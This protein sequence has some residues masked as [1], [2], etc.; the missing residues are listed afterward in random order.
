[1][2]DTRRLEEL[3]GCL[4]LRAPLRLL[5]T[6]GRE[7]HDA[8]IAGI[9]DEHRAV[10]GDGD[11]ARPVERRGPF[12]LVGAVRAE[13]LNATVPGV[14][15]VDELVRADGDTTRILELARRFAALAPGDER[16][17]VRIELLDAVV[18]EVGDVGVPL[19]VECQATRL[20][21]LAARILVADFLSAFDL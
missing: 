15:D 18:D 12:E 7:T 17:E 3:T 1:D 19:R 8:V 20:V 21:E 11:A 5:R 10:V 13:D 2:G 6:V 14:G 9:G 4:A 16:M